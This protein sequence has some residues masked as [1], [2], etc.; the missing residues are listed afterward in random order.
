MMIRSSHGTAH[1]AV[2]EAA[3]RRL[4]PAQALKA[5]SR[6]FYVPPTLFLGTL[7]TAFASVDFGTKTKSF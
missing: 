7:A 2:H 5:K 1:D 4:D 3:M 6:I